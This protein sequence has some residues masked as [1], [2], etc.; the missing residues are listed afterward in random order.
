MVPGA[1]VS[2]V[3][4]LPNILSEQEILLKAADYAIAEG[5]LDPSYDEYILDHIFRRL[6]F[7]FPAAHL[8]RGP[9][10]RWV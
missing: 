9:L 1:P 6:T 8:T 7:P 5:V 3:R 2:D 4:P 10:A